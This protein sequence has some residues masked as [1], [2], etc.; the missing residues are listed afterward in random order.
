[1]AT[2]VKFHQFIEDVMHGV[3]DLSSDQI[4]VALS[5]T[6]P[7]AAT[8]EVLADIVEITY[9]NL[10]ARDVT[11]VSSA[12]TAGTYKLTLTD[13]TLTA[14]GTVGPFRYV[15]IYNNTPTAPA[16]PLIA[17]YDRGSSLTL[18]NTDQFTIDFNDANGFFQ[19]A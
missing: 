2:Y 1:M 11:T 6:A 3:H 16:D 19:A 10:S 5:N 8:D 14:S 17:M 9:T 7:S 18:E 4:T 13:L 12:H 15:I